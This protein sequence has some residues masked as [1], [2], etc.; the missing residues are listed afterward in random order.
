MDSSMELQSEKYE[1]LQESDRSDAEDIQPYR[2]QLYSRSSSQR[3]LKFCGGLFLA[4]S[5]VLNVFLV[6]SNYQNTKQQ[7]GT[8]WGKWDE[9]DEFAVGLT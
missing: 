2:P 3:L 9:I 8:K 7:V 5:V 6:T 4:F 1:L